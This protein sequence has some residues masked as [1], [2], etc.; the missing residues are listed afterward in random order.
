M[1]D[2]AQAVVEPP[3]TIVNQDNEFWSEALAQMLDTKKAIPLLYP[4]Q[5]IMYAM[6]VYFHT[7]QN[8]NLKI[9]GSC[10]EII[11]HLKCMLSY[12]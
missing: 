12:I 2:S 6:S 1:T 8:I 7:V 3:A 4:F 9:I 5:N 11:E 10:K